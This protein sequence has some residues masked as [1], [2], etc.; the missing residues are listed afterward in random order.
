MKKK[1]DSETLKKM[2]YKDY[3]QTEYWQMLSEQVK[4][5]A[6]YKCQVCGKTSKQATLHVHHNTYEHRGEE[7]KHME[8]LVCLCGDCHQYFHDREKINKQMENLD[9][10]LQ[11]IVERSNEIN[12]Q[13]QILKRTNRELE[14]EKEYSDW[15]LRNYYEA[16][17]PT[18]A[19]ADIQPIHLFGDKDDDLPF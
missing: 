4:A 8:D 3:L 7:Y 13:L 16:T 6:K 9:N 19:K 1:I 5:N 10:K 11:I 17:R 18:K 14:E 15:K 2:S 12:K